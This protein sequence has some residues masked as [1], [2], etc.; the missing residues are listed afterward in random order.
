MFREMRRKRQALSP[1]ENVAI[2]NR[3]TSGVLAVFGD[4]GYPYAVPL[5]YVYDGS[6]S[7]STVQ[8]ADISLM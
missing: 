6:R 3:G 8:K 1:E 5:S 4:D 7:T 2:L